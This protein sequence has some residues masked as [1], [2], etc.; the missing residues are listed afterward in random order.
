M[1][2]DGT[3]PVEND[4]RRCVGSRLLGWT[5]NVAILAY[6]RAVVLKFW[7]RELQTTPR[8]WGAVLLHSIPALK[9]GRFRALRI[10][11]KVRLTTATPTLLCSAASR[12]SGTCFRKSA[13]SSVGP[14]VLD[15]SVVSIKSLVEAARNVRRVDGDDGVHHTVRG[16]DLDRNKEGG[17]HG[18]LRRLPRAENRPTEADGSARAVG[19][20]AVPGR[21]VILHNRMEPVSN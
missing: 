17:H 3:R 7:Y 1:G 15:Q 8:A 16:R 11:N 6:W 10:S 21:W 14:P 19:V 20:D 5:D 4:H 13:C 2:A 9:R 18:A 12:A